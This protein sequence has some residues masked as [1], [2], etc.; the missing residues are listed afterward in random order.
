[1][2]NDESV[3]NISP[4]LLCVVRARA[5]V[6]HSAHICAKLLISCDDL[7]ALLWDPSLS[8]NACVWSIVI[9]LERYGVINLP[10]TLRGLVACVVIFVCDMRPRVGAL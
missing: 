8:V 10:H 5:S 4:P 2:G 3:S 6:Y 1:M 7:E 9:G